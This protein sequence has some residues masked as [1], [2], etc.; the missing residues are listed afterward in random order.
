MTNHHGTNSTGQFAT[1][2]A[3]YTGSTSNQE[4]QRL[5]S[6]NSP[7]WIWSLPP[8]S[9]VTGGSRAPEGPKGDVEVSPEDLRLL[10]DPLDQEGEGHIP[11]GN[12]HQGTLLDLDY[13]SSSDKS[14]SG[15]GSSYS[16]SSTSSSSD[17]LAFARE[18]SSD[19]E[20]RK[21][22]KRT[23]TSKLNTSPKERRIAN[24]KF[25]ISNKP[26]DNRVIQSF[27][28]Y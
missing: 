4:L 11:H 13:S 18:R 6:L 20:G 17:P 8:T 12:G 3:A 14:S 22:T 27:K 15:S 1:T 28:L 10:E 9:S 7:L 26:R 16:D 25:S 24:S 23:R 2:F 19:S 5:A 21:K